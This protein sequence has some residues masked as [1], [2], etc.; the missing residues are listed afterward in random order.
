MSVKL[1]FC[2]IRRNEDVDF[3]NETRPDYIGFIFY[4]KSK[5]NIS[6]ELAG[7]LKARLDKGI[8]TVGVFVN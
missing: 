8:K 1:K 6:P 7:Q 2:G 4:E 3:A 5:R